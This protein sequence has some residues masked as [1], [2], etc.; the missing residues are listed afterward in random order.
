M[1]YKIQLHERGFVLADVI[2]E[3]DCP[4]QY[5]GIGDIVVGT[6]DS[7]LWTGST[8]VDS[9]QHTLVFD[10]GNVRKIETR[11]DLSESAEPW[12]TLWR[13]APEFSYED[14][15]EAAAL[16]LPRRLWG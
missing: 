11:S 9:P 12:A 2:L 8:W 4:N 13:R 5:G 10:F 7:G 6:T 14:Y 1:I 3:V 16:L 15:H